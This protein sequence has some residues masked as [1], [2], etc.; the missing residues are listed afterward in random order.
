[1]RPPEKENPGSGTGAARVNRQ[2]KRI[3]FN[4]FFGK[5]QTICHSYLLTL[6]I[7][8]DGHWEPGLSLAID[9]VLVEVWL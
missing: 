5:Y 9:R 8:P 6:L 3:Y 1:M 7:S 2:F 4:R